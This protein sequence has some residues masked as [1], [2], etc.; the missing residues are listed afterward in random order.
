M[1]EFANSIEVLISENI[2][3]KMNLN[4]GDDILMYFIQNPT[5]VRKFKVSGVYKT[6]LTEFD[7]I[8]IIGDLKQIQKLDNVRSMMIR[9]RL[10]SPVLRT[11]V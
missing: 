3:R 2:S 1:D 4:I 10:R 7:E 9:M 8:M 5:R 11:M 6:D